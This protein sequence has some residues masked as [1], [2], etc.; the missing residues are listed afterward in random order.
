VLDSHRIALQDK[1]IGRAL[2]GLS[3]SMVGADY[4]GETVLAAN[5]PIT[6]LRWGLIAKIDVREIRTPFIQAGILA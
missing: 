6:A 3:G 4:R 2:S 1:P 5:E